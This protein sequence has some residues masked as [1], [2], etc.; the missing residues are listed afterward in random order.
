MEQSF[1][2]ESL[3]MNPLKPILIRAANNSYSGQYLTEQD[4]VEQ[5]ANL[6]HV[7]KPVF[8]DDGKEVTTKVEQPNETVTTHASNKN[9]NTVEKG[10]ESSQQKPLDKNETFD[11]QSKQQAKLNKEQSQ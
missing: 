6:L 7:Q 5:I 4:L 11:E 8:K 3:G 2:R 10:A 1:V 9:G